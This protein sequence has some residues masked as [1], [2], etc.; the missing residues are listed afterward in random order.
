MFFDFLLFFVGI[1]ACV[2]GP[3]RGGAGRGGAGAWM[4][5]DKSASEAT[6]SVH[7]IQWASAETGIA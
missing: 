7:T 4:G 2:V 1:A 5:A 3:W 6:S